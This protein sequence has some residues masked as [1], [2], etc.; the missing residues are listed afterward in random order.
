MTL[1]MAAL[2]HLP[3]RIV[4]PRV[5]DRLARATAGGFGAAMP[6]WS[7]APFPE[8]LAAYAEWT[9]KRAGSAGS[10]TPP[11]LRRNARALGSAARRWLG[12]R[13]PQDALEALVLLY[14]HIGIEIT[15]RG[16]GTAAGGVAAGGAPRAHLAD[17]EVTRCFFADYYCESACRVMS[18]LDAGVVDGLF[19]GA[20]LEF[21]QRITSGSP[22]CRATIRSEGV[23]A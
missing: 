16:V 23:A 17:L 19:G 12:I 2:R 20:S 15:G 18:A 14:R 22:C 7:G 21:S 11:E 8:R 6:D 3:D 5:L 10:E 9:A 4:S 13:H 1:R